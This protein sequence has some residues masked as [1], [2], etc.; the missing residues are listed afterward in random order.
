MDHCVAWVEGTGNAMTEALVAVLNKAG[1]SIGIDLFKIMDVGERFVKP[2]LV[3]PQEIDNNPIVLGYSGVY[4]TFLLHATR[5]AEKLEIDAR[6]I[7]VE[8]GKRR[9]VG[10]QEDAILDVALEI[11]EKRARISE[12][13]NETISIV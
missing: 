13:Q 8:L 6:D 2:L 10:G 9:T 1:Y 5:V 3:R 4:S 12:V 11:A 7:L